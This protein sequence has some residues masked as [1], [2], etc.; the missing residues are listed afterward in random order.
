LVDNAQ[1]AL[2]P[3][4]ATVWRIPHDR[5]SK[6]AQKFRHLLRLK[7]QKAAESKGSKN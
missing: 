2:A 6:R 1:V 5:L 7:P 3:N 4:A